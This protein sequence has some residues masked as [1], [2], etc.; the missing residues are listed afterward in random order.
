MK[1]DKFAATTII[2]LT[3]L[4]DV[5]RDEEDRELQSLVPLDITEEDLTQHFQAMIWAMF[6]FYEKVSGDKGKDLLDFVA[7]INRLVFQRLREEQEEN[8]KEEGE[9]DA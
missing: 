4:S 8:G 9:T 6:L 3:A 5:Y 7:L 1:K 2:F